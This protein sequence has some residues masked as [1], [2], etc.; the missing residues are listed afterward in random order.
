MPTS[1]RASSLGSCSFI[2][3][4]GALLSPTIFFLSNIWPPSAYLI[5]VLVGVISL[6]SSCLFLVE[7]KNIHLDRVDEESVS[8]QE[9]QIPMVSRRQW[10]YSVKKFKW[11]WNLSEIIILKRF[12]ETIPWWS[13]VSFRE[14]ITNWDRFRSTACKYFN[15]IQA[16]KVTLTSPLTQFH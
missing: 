8:V 2:A 13:L 6:I 12:T 3:R 11:K 1:M 16:I 10:E 4:I 7:T 9:E 15:K 14:E 5:V